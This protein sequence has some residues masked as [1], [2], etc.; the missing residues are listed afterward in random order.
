MKPYQ[1][2]DWLYQKHWGEGLSIEKIARIC[3]CRYQKIRKYLKLFGLIKTY[4]QSIE[5]NPNDII[6]KKFNR[7]KTIKLEKMISRTYP[8]GRKRDCYYYLCK[9]DCGTK[10]IISRNELK[11]GRIK[12]C[13]CLRKERHPRLP[14]G[15]A[16]FRQI[17]A[18]YKRHNV[19][20]GKMR[21]DL[22][23]K[24]FR[25]LTKQNCYYCNKAPIQ[26]G[27][28]KSMP[29]GIYFYNGLDRV[30]NNKGYTIENVVPCC[31]I[32]NHAK[33]DMPYDEF[34]GWIKRVNN[35]INQ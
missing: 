34:I 11:N 1:D 16:S 33:S 6:G 20:R 27:R 14:E 23:E 29:N 32:C 5:F 35:F 2:R 21:W 26:R 4:H 9:C 28:L 24:Q 30:D 22:T 31:G 13:G 3:K 25:I 8:S 7:L 19:E 15:E 18:A 10:K 17:L 12:S